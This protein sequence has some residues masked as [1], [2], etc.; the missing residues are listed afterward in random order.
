M[1]Y[2]IIL[3]IIAAGIAYWIWR[4]PSQAKSFSTKV[5]D[6]WK[7]TEQAIKDAVNKAETKK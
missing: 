1:I 3:I 6:E 7:S 4:N 2:I 5:D